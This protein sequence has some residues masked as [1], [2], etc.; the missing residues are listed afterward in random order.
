[1]LSAKFFML[2]IPMKPFQ[3]YSNMRDSNISQNSNQF[4]ENLE[5]YPWMLISV[6]ANK[7]QQK[8]RKNTTKLNV[9]V[10]CVH[11]PNANKQDDEEEAC[12]Q[13]ILQNN[14]KKKNVDRR[15]AD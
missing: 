10:S 15:L 12:F 9:C 1:M 14:K 4:N 5:I 8:Q 11:V 13:G 2:H 6:F 3:L 7:Q